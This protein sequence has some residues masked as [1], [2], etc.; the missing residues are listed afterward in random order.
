M[1]VSGT[2]PEVTQVDSQRRGWQCVIP[3]INR[4]APA[5]VQTLLENSLPVRGCRIFSTL[6]RSLREWEGGLQSF[7]SLLDKYWRS[8]PDRPYLSHYY[9]PSQTNNLA[10]TMR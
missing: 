5:V 1:I 7:K 6:P 2:D 10:V 8:V 9:L 3:N 4:R